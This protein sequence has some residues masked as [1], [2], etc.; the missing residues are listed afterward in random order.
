MKF[1]CI[2]IGAIE[3]LPIEFEGE[4]YTLQEIAQIS[5]KGAQMVVVNASSFPQAIKHILKALN[6]SGMGL[7]P[8]QDGTT[9]FIHIPK[10]NNFSS[11]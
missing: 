7:N 9:L 3:T 10:Y 11:L 4:H 8:Q 1:L 5:K 2:T 6:E